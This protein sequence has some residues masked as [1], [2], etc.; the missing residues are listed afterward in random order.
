MVADG[1]NIRVLV[2]E[3]EESY[4]QALSAGLRREGFDVDV[5]ADGA[6]GLSIFADRTPNIVLLDM[7]LPGMHGWRSAGG[8]A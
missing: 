3:D 1:G 2:V 5:A 8:C 7:L 4:R 6:E